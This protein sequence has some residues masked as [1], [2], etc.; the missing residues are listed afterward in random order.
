MNWVGVMVSSTSSWATTIFRMASV[1][2]SVRMACVVLPASSSA[3]S[4]AELVQQLLEP[5]LVDLVDDDEEHLVVLVRLR[6][7]R[8]QQLVQPQ[9]AG[10]GDGF[11]HGSSPRLASMMSRVAATAAQT[12]VKRVVSG[13]RP[14]LSR[15]GVR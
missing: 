1:R 8:G 11:S 15:S 5:Q 7:L 2:R 9:V 3:C 4:L 12:S 10:I 13:D 14:N 6:L